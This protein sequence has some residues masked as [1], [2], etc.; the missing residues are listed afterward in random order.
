MQS[1]DYDRLPIEQRMQ[2]FN[3][4]LQQTWELIKELRGLLAGKEAR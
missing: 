3:D 2:I 1:R 4:S